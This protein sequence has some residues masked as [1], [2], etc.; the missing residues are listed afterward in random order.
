MQAAGP[1]GEVS[2]LSDDVDVLVRGVMLTKGTHQVVSTSEVRGLGC[3][4]C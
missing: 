1:L 4:L 3:A 2:F